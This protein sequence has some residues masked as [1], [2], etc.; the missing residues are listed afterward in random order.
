MEHNSDKRTQA[1]STPFTPGNCKKAKLVVLST[2]TRSESTEGYDKTHIGTLHRG[3]TFQLP[4]FPPK[5]MKLRITG[6][7]SSIQP[8]KINH[9]GATTTSERLKNCPQQ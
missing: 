9:Q 8:S 4:L 2:E 1:E 5:R 6:F 3:A 7:Y